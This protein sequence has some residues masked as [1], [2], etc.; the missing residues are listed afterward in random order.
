VVL[1]DALVLVELTHLKAFVRL[2]DDKFRAGTF[3]MM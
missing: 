1:S 2:G 3:G